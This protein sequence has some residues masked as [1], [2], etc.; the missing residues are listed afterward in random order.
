MTRQMT[1]YGIATALLGTLALG[2]CS[3]EKNAAQDITAPVSGANVKFFNLGVSAPGINFFVNDTKVTAVS[4]AS[5]SPPPVTPNAACT[6]SGVP[7]ASGT[8]YGS[9][10]GG[11]FYQV[12]QAG[13]VTLTGRMADTAAANMGLTVA[14]AAANLETGKYY[15]FY[16]SGIYNTTAKTTEAFVVEDPLPAFDLTKSYVRFVNASSNAPALTLYAKNTTTATEGAVGAAVAYKSA[17]AFTEIPAA[18]YD[19]N[20]RAA[21]SG[22]NVVTLTGTSFAAGRVYTISLRGDMTVSSTTAANRPILQSNA[23][24]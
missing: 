8:A 9:V 13:S 12:V 20:L 22:T 16:T 7:S 10:A 24:R 23:N 6:A 4:S 11:S 17:G 14:T 3:Y 1:R 2:A 18:S 5:C 21:G 15:S 19:L